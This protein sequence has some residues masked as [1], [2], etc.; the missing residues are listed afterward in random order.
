MAVGGAH[1]TFWAIGAVALIWNVSGS[2][3]FFVQLDADQVAAMPDSYRAIIENRPAWATVAFAL[4]VFGGTLGCLLLLLRKSLSFYVFIASLLGVIATW[5]HA[6]SMTNSTIE[7][8]PVLIGTSLSLAVAALLIWY[9]KLA[10]R[11]GWIS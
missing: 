4:T 8:T 5:V 7:Y 10:E 1:W 11:K 2:I 3:N 6:F 9:S